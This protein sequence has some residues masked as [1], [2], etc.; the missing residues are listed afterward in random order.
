M[1]RY[2]KIVEIDCDTFTSATGD[3]LDCLELVSP[4]GGYVYVA[5]DDNREDEMRISLDCFDEETA[6]A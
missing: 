1:A 2:F 3:Y 4:A 6:D 5:V